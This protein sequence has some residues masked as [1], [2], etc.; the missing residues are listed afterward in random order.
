MKTPNKQTDLLRRRL[1]GGMA[2]AG[3]L[4][5]AGCSG[6][7][8]SPDPTQAAPVGDSPQQPPPSSSPPRTPP[9]TQPPPPQ[10]PV[11]NPRGLHVSITE[12][13]HS[14]R[15]VTWFTDGDFVPETY[16]EFDS[17]E[18]GMSAEDIQ[19]LP[20]SMR[21]AGSSEPT[22]GV[23]AHTHRATASSIDPDKPLRYRVGS[24]NGWSPV[25]VIDPSPTGAWTFTHWGDQGIDIKGQRVAMEAAQHNSDLL[26]LAGDISYA[27]G[28]QG[29]WDIY[30]DRYH[31][32]LANTVTMAAPGNHEDEDNGGL[33]FK[34]R[35]SHP[36]PPSSTATGGNPGSTFYSFDYNRIH[37]L[38]TTA[39][40]LITDGT[41]PEEIAAIEADLSVAAAL[42]AAGQIDFI[43]VL[44]HFTIWTDQAGR[45]PANP[46]LVALEEDIIVR[47]GVDV[48]LVGHDHVYQRSVPMAYGMPNPLGYVQMMVGTGGQSVRLFDDDGIQPW[49]A[50]EF[51][52]IG[53]AVY[54]VNGRSINVTYY[55]AAPASLDDENRNTVTAPFEVVDQ[56]ILQARD[57][58]MARSFVRPA[59]A[60]E[61]LL[62]DYD[63]IARHTRERN[64][65]ALH[66]CA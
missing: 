6:S 22:F 61:T 23:D 64:K 37:F 43:M 5:L 48:L 47:Y 4:S 35:F 34:N 65:H 40:A 19:T 3:A 27:D 15:T 60:P 33:A 11:V 9:V 57:P 38:V 14:S 31:Y 46:S 54:E 29:E 20:L 30:F 56:F 50:K 28:V 63:G 44:Q 39:G 21:F 17:V 42:R 1:L 45:G 2:G 25:Q 52:G 13:T 7:S 58:M 41:L 18:D 16:I 49:S 62:A 24:P 51:V 53:Y 32:L 59:R 36:N 66:H 55:G 8:S 26:L 10:A 12:D